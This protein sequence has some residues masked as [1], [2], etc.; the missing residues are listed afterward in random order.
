M[1]YGEVAVIRECCNPTTEQPSS[2]VPT[3]GGTTESSI[4][5]ISKAAVHPVATVMK[6]KGQV[7][8]PN[9]KPAR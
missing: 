8:P 5:N 9:I 3:H 4:S 2:S 1:V 6:K 7:V